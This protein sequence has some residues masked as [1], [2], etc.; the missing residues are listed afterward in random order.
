MQNASETT[1]FCNHYPS[2]TVTCSSLI[3]VSLDYCKLNFNSSVD[4]KML[5]LRVHITNAPKVQSK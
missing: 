1:K 4:S 5:P 2:S 3:S